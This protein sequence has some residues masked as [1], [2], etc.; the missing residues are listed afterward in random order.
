MPSGRV[1]RRAAVSSV[2][3]VLVQYRGSLR[4]CI[5]STHRAL[6]AGKVSLS[7]PAWEDREVID[8]LGRWG[9]L[10]DKPDYAGLLT[11]G[12][13]PYTEDPADL[14]GVDVAIV[15]APT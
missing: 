14:E 8:P 9:D 4:P 12:S 11:F 10:G 5:A 7:P 15:G 1:G 3:L 6:T 13:L 2:A